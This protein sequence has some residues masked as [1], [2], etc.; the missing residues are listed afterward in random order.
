MT[1]SPTTTNTRSINYFS[2]LEANLI[3]A[4]KGKY[5]YQDAVYFNNKTK[6]EITCTIHG[7]FWQ[8]PS[9]HLNGRGCGACGII[10]CAA[11]NR[12]TIEDFIKKSTTT[13]DGKYSYNNA[14]LGENNKVPVYVTCPEHGDFKVTPNNHM[15]GLTGGCP[16]CKIK[17][18]QEQPALWS[19]TKW[20]QSGK[21]SQQFD[22][23]KLYVIRCWKGSEEFLKIGKTYTT[24]GKRLKHHL[25][26]EYEVLCIKEGS[27]RFISELEKS[28]HSEI[29]ENKH[30]PS[31][32][33][34]GMHE[35]FNISTKELVLLKLKEMHWHF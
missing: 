15:R 35:C 25:P 24:I 33:F 8:L 5:T 13:Y 18:L 4:H 6:L 16:S 21:A 28:I 26:Y 34:G 1:I 31:I 27:A 17:R 22:S 23:F 20:E 2:T 30:C 10:K 29:K 9:D 7:N 3:E 19:Y 14:V 12:I 11:S 32:E